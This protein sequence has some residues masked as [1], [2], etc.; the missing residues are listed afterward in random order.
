MTRTAISEGYTI[1]PYFFDTSVIRS[2]YLKT[3]QTWFA[4]QLSELSCYPATDGA[5]AH[6]ALPVRKQL[7]N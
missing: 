1:R 7:A 5:Q 3:P 4:P 6:C 2:A